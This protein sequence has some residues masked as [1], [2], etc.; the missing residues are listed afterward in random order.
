MLGCG[1]VASC[2]ALCS[3]GGRNQ[4]EV[5]RLATHVPEIELRCAEREQMREQPGQLSQRASSP[6]KCSPNFSGFGTGQQH[7]SEQPGCICTAISGPSTSPKDEI[8]R[9]S[10]GNCSKGYLQR[11]DLGGVPSRDHVR[12][13]ET[14]KASK[15]RIFAE[16]LCVQVRVWLLIL[17]LPNNFIA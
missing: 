3:P 9:R 11:G 6:C 10:T 2:L 12:Q 7:T 14:T 13:H 17:H 4:N 15:A 5:G 16:E 8:C 1:V